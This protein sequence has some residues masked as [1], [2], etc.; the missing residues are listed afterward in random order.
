MLVEAHQQVALAD[1]RDRPPSHVGV[2]DRCL[3]R[4]AV[5]AAVLAAPVGIHARVEGQVGTVVA[6]DQAARGV[7]EKAGPGGS[8]LVALGIGRVGFAFVDDEKPACPGTMCARPIPRYLV[9]RAEKLERK[10]NLRARLPSGGAELTELL[11]LKP[12]W[13]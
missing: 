13:T 4:E 6:G 5:D 10:P 3:R 9:D 1:V 7:A 12:K 11:T 2:E 8:R